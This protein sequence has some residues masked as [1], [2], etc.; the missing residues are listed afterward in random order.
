MQII[1]LLSR[2]EL[3]SSSEESQTKEETDQ[4]QRE[5]LIVS[6]NTLNQKIAAL[7]EELG[8]NR[9]LIQTLESEKDQLI[10][11]KQD[12]VV[13][14]MELAV[15]S[16]SRTLAGDI[17]SDVEITGLKELNEELIKKNQLLE[18]EHS[19]I[20]STMINQITDLKK[21]NE[22][23]SLKNQQLED[24]RRQFEEKSQN[25]LSQVSF[26]LDK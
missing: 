19:T 20:K 17:L 10:Q 14:Q 26:L 13:A 24:E 23:L 5:Q 15:S 16:E 21:L 2:T 9:D 3:K 12:L 6:N 25:A 8:L 1:L 7:E 4:Q 22:E 18:D 11:E